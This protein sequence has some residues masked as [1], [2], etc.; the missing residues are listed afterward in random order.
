MLRVELSMD[1]FRSIK[2]N[3]EKEGDKEIKK[4]GKEIEQDVILSYHRGIS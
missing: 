2:E 3:M 4:E 1:L